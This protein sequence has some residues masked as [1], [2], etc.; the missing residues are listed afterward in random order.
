MD[1]SAGGKRKLL[2]SGVYPE[3][4]LKEA[5]HKQADGCKLIRDGI[6][7]MEAKR[8]HKRALKAQSENSFESIAREWREQNKAR[9]IH[10]HAINVLGSLQRDLFL[11]LGASPIHEDTAPVI[12][13]IIQRI[14]KYNAS[15]VA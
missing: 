1:C 11:T 13:E 15:H 7:P 3:V 9:W 6:D 2:A 4:N 8:E 14:E 12:L 10:H 5:R